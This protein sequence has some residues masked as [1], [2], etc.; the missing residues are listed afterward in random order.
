MKPRYPD[1]NFDSVKPHWLRNRELAQFYNAAS[2]IPSHIEPYLVWVMRKTLSELPA[3][4]EDLRRDVEI[5]NKQEIQHCK[6]HNAFNKVLREKGYPGLIEYEQALAADFN[7]FFETKSLRFNVAYS[8][9]FE[10]IGSNNAEIFF[11]VLPLLE[12][13][14][15]PEAVE[16]W[17]WHLAEEFEHRHVCFEVYRSLF[18]KGLFGGYFYRC[19]GYLYAYF[20][21]TS[22]INR[23][24]DYM[25]EIDRQSM[26][27]EQRQRS[28]S[29][30]KTYRRNVF[31]RD[32]R[33]FLKVLSP[34]YNP[35]HK[36]MTADMKNYLATVPAENARVQATGA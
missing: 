8:E 25:I 1:L 36:S 21:L 24:A 20:H 22:H 27:D 11:A 13:S 18:G 6:Q 31:M 29:R 30:V 10:A 34:F 32:M 2:T 14:A 16:L 9:G 26:S 23:V 7:R 28:I 33:Q 17:K 35:A 19:Y 4:A 3:D 5:F 12:K 15:D